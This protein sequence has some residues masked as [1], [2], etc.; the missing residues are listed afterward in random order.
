MS[1]HTQGPNP[2]YKMT[3]VWVD[4]GYEVTWVWDGRYELTWVW[5]DWHPL[6]LG[7]SF[8]FDCLYLLNVLGCYKSLLPWSRMQRWN[9]VGQFIV[10]V[11]A[12]GLV[13]DCTR[14]VPLV[15]V[16]CD[17]CYK[18]ATFGT[19]L[20]HSRPQPCLSFCRWLKFHWVLHWILLLPR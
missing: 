20:L 16:F 13:L 7:K 4:I 6:T 15:R 5:L 9:L 10:A 14:R 1:C 17:G 12:A 11:S 3:W 18:P 19:W 8:L 2:W